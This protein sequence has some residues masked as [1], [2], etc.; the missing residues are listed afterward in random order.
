MSKDIQG[1]FQAM[2]AWYHWSDENFPGQLQPRGGGGRPTQVTFLTNRAGGGGPSLPRFTLGL[3]AFTDVSACHET[4]L[5]KGGDWGARHRG[6]SLGIEAP[7]SSIFFNGVT[8][9]NLRKWQNGKSVKASPKLEGQGAS[10]L[11]KG[12]GSGGPLPRGR[13][14]CLLSPNPGRA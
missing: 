5:A 9:W 11:C 8:Q 1:I 7:F 13:A 10:H 2:L 3:P 6:I 12:G 14:F 4:L